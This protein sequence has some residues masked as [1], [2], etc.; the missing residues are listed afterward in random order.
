[1]A[2][3]RSIRATFA[4]PRVLRESAFYFWRRKLRR[5][6]QPAGAVNPLSSEVLPATPR[7]PSHKRRLRSRRGA[8]S[9]VPV[10]VV[11]DSPLEASRAV[12]IVLARGRSVRVP[13]GF[14]RQTLA[15]VL[16]VLE[17][18]PC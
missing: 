18:P 6:D 4:R 15:D 3:G 2:R 12:E 5:R 14:D 16:A 13:A 11:E 17:A 7:S 8:V 1:M 10:Q 9:F